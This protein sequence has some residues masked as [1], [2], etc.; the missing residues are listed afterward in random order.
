MREAK[1]SSERQCVMGAECECNFID[2]SNPF[3][4]V[5]FTVPNQVPSEDRHMCVLCHRRFVQSLFHEMIYNGKEIHGVIQRYGNICGCEGEYAK[6]VAMIC[7]PNGPTHCMPF[8]AI[9]HQR[10]RYKI[11]ARGGVRYLVQCRMSPQDFC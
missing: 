8:P 10:N 4:G 9:S 6:E 3:V 5:E 1:D 11:V 2:R 7:P